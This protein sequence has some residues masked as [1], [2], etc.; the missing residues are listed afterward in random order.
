MSHI[1]TKEIFQLQCEIGTII[2]RKRRD[3]M[4]NTKMC[5]NYKQDIGDY[6]YLEV[7][8]EYPINLA[9]K[10]KRRKEIYL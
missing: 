6:F 4:Y 2:L 7:D 8:N 10:K 1:G 5:G 3:A 9:P